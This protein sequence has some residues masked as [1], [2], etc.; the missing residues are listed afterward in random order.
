MSRTTDVR[1]RYN[2]ES[3]N[4]L[5]SFHR[6][7][8]VLATFLSHFWDTSDTKSN[9]SLVTNVLM[10]SKW[11]RVTMSIFFVQNGSNVARLHSQ[12]KPSKGPVQRL[13]RK[14]RKAFLL[15]QPSRKEGTGE[16]IFSKNIWIVL[17]FEHLLSLVPA[18]VLCDKGL[19]W[20]RADFWCSE[21]GCQKIQ[22]LHKTWQL[23]WDSLWN[24]C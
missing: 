17:H 9:V 15:R 3:F 12:Q 18:K 24:R 21:E 16:L 1:G 6:G 23:V 13:R 5:I 2:Y 20:G 4:H 22:L 8:E 7:K 10:L 11:K 19:L 14:V